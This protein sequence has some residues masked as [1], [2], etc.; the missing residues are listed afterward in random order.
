MPII[1]FLRTLSTVGVDSRLSI[2]F[3]L[4]FQLP[5]EICSL[6]GIRSL[7]QIDWSSEGVCDD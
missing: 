1:S 4:K 7:A 3:K 6:P 5:E 2:E